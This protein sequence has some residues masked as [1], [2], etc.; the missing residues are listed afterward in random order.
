MVTTIKG[1]EEM[2]V[3]PHLSLLIY[4][5]TTGT[6]GLS[7]APL[8]IGRMLRTRLPMYQ[9]QLRPKTVNQSAQTKRDRNKNRGR[10]KTTTSTTGKNNC[11]PWRKIL[12]GPRNPRIPALSWGMRDSDITIPRDKPCYFKKKSQPGLPQHT[13]QMTSSIV[14]QLQ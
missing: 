6:S 14:P 13:T 8:L 1:F 4:T 3:N 7:P 11:L 9:D 2:S 12:V 10:I 5:N